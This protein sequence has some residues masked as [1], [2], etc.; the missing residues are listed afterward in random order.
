MTVRFGFFEQELKFQTRF[1][2]NDITEFDSHSAFVINI[3]IHMLKNHNVFSKMCV[4]FYFINLD[5]D[6]SYVFS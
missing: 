6:R 2:A 3:Y 5:L 1:D 4:T